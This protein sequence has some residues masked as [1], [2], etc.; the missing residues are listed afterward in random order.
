MTYIFSQTELDPDTTECTGRLTHSTAA[1]FRD[2]AE[3][4]KVGAVSQ[5]IEGGDKRVLGA[6]QRGIDGVNR[7]ATS[8]A[9]I[10]QKWTVLG[11]DFSIPG[12]ELG[13]ILLY[14]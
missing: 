5:I 7:G 9:Q 14:I 4:A 10:I 6:I 11:A 2:N 13:E 1:W 12:G 3:G 8:R